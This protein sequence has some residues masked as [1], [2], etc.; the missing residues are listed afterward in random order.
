MKTPFSSQKL[1]EMVD[2]IEALLVH[3]LW[4]YNVAA[5]NTRDDRR[6]LFS[7][8]RDDE[9]YR[10][11]FSEDSYNSQVESGIKFLQSRRC[12]E[13]E[14]LEAYLVIEERAIAAHTMQ[15]D[16]ALEER[17]GS[18]YDIMCRMNQVGI[19]GPDH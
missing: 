6:S 19:P 2:K 16:K 3:N 14:R 18:T 9:K 17:G 12:Q 15:R 13:K 5:S 11:V 8:I 4:S 1:K 7:I 10:L